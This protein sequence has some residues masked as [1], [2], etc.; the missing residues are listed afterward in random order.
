MLPGSLNHEAVRWSPT[1]AVTVLSTPVGD[2]SEALSINKAG[3]AVG[4]VEDSANVTTAMYWGPRGHA[5][6]LNTILGSA[7]TD[8]VA[9]GINNAGDIVGTGNYNGLMEAF[10][11]IPVKAAGAMDSTHYVESHHNVLAA[12]AV[13]TPVTESAAH[14]FASVGHG[15][16]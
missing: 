4:Y 9:T 10:E 1:G 7:W 13:H 12:S 6:S 16:G 5:A 15:P 8:T 11:L 3:A 14:G 2:Q